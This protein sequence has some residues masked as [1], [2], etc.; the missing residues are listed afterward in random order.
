MTILRD[1]TNAK[2][3]Q[4]ESLP[5]IQTIIKGN[6]TVELYVSY[7]Y[8]LFHIYSKLETLADNAALLDKLPGIHRSSAI[9]QDLLELNSE[10]SR[11]LMPST[12]RYLQ[13][14]TNLN[15]KNCKMLLAHVYVRHMGDL[16][17]GKLMARVI[18]GSGK[19]YQFTDR[20]ALIK[21]FNDQ[22]TLDLGDEANIAFDFFIDIFT[23]LYECS[24]DK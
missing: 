17:G 18:P 20:P 12:V 10:Y 7:L 8:E 15:T 4:V 13:Y 19:T 14:L 6:V 1:K 5:L 11:S 2:H 24:T 21:A 16:Y 23:E 9:K 3:R 22:L